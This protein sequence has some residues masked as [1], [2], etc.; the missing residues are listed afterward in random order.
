MKLLGLTGGIGSG[1][2][3]VASIMASLG[4]CVVDADVLARQAVAPGTEALSLIIEHFGHEVLD[5]NQALNR[6]ELG[7]RVFADPS[8]RQTLEHIV[9]PAVAALAAAA[10]QHAREKGVL[11]AVYDV[12]LLF[13]NHLENSFDK[14]AVVWADLSHRRRR[15][16]Q[17]DALSEEE[18]NDRI[19]AQL[20]LEDKVQRAD[21]VINNNGSVEQTARLAEILYALLTQGA[22]EASTSRMRMEHSDPGG[23][24]PR[25]KGVSNG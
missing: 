11:L 2:S 25:E 21:Y 13:E 10:F 14:T 12:P 3:T 4:A 9:H 6:R 16:S 19:A 15:L 5:T 20:P 23:E 17:R 24:S 1:K 7:R 22:K 18:I 8:A